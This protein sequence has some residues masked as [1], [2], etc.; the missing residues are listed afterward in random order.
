MYAKQPAI[1]G[2]LAIVPSHPTDDASK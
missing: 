2:Q 1:K